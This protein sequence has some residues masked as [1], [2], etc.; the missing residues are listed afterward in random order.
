MNRILMIIGVVVLAGVGAGCRPLDL[1]REHS[2]PLPVCE[3]HALEMSPEYI[4]VYG[5]SGY[6]PGYWKLSRENF[7]HH[8]GHRYTD[9][10]NTDS[11][12]F[13]RDIIDFVCPE[14]DRLYN[15]YW[16]QEEQKLALA[17]MKK[18]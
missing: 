10:W 4:Y 16:D 17:R 15:E 18:R 13:E 5:F 6:L 9:E 3:L 7:P 11:N 8:G 14:C 2:G 1:T 12:F